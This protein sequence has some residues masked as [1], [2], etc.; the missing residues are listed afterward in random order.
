M[1]I[2]KSIIWFGVVILLLLSAC[3][4]G[5]KS[6]V[7]KEDLDNVNESGMPIV[8]EEIEL[9]FFAGQSPASADDWNDVMIFNEYKEMTNMNINWKLIP[10]EGLEEK[11]NLALSGGTLPDAFHNAS[12]PVK[13]IFKY[14]KQGT[15]ISLNDLIDDYAPN[16][17]ALFEENPEIGKALTH[18]DGNIYSLPTLDDPEFLSLRISAEPWF[19]QDWLD[20][21][22]MDVP[23]TTDE[24]YDYLKAV[25]ETDLIGDGEGKEVP[26]GAQSIGQ[27]LNWLRGSY[28][29]GNR[30]VSSGYLDKDPNEDKVRFFPIT[31]EYK[32]M[33]EYVHKLFDEGLIEQNIFSLE[34]DQFFANGADGVYGSTYVQD[35]SQLFSGEHKDDYTAGVALEGPHGDKAFS[36]IRHPVVI[37][38]AFAITKD[39]AHPAATMRWIDHFYS[40]EGM[41]LFMMGIEGETYEITEDGDYEYVEDIRDNPDGLNLDQAISRYLTWPGG[42]YPGI[43]KE[44]FFKGAEGSERS[45][46]A[47]EKIEDDLIDDVWP[48]FT[49]TDDESKKLNA[50]GSDIEKYVG[51]MQDKFISGDK[52]FEEWDD[53]VETIEGMNLEEY[54]DIQQAAYERY[55]EID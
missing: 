52:S 31:D 24:F 40:D 3:G 21:L 9:D 25:K 41:E 34:H 30:G 54:L 38:G 46:E 8:D 36:Y 53:Y 11:R 17:Q 19:R 33:L 18:P 20:E 14:G 51:E 22:G 50:F 43:V 28:G 55:Q 42:G 47:A 37:P 7:Q 32:E 1:H 49:Y 45:I 29:I 27:L 6:A 16:L 39:N 10:D 2:K 26:F 5:G 15:L 44:A 48:A 4:S 23:K 35:P 13:D 12:I